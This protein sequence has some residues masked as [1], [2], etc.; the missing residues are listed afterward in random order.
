[1]VFD[2]IYLIEKTPY[3]PLPLF[4]GISALL[5]LS[6]LPFVALPVDRWQENLKWGI[7]HLII[8]YGLL[9]VLLVQDAGSLLLVRMFFS[10]HIYPLFN[11]LG[12]G[13]GNYSDDH[14]ISV[15]C[16]LPFPR[17]LAHYHGNHT[18]ISVHRNP[19]GNVHRCPD[20][21]KP[22]MPTTDARI[23]PNLRQFVHITKSTGDRD[24]PICNPFRVPVPNSLDDI[25]TFYT[26]SGI[27][28]GVIDN[29]SSP[30]P[31]ALPAKLSQIEICAMYS[32]E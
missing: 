13:A 10:N 7:L 12:C 19:D 28:G 31:R 29:S 23:I 2:A 22:G 17:K 14:R 32:G 5:A 30:N 6:Y 21:P 4:L 24:K 3:V 1:M 26:F 11:P 25:L 18:G 15:V 8:G 9:G 16:R 27:V 20:Y